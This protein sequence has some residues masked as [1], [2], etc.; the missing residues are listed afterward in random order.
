MRILI[1]FL[2]S[3]ILGF[4][5]KS[6]KEIARPQNLKTI[7]SSRTEKLLIKTRTLISRFPENKKER[8][9]DTAKWIPHKSSTDF[10]DINGNLIRTERYE[11]GGSITNYYTTSGYYNYQYN[12]KGKLEYMRTN[13]GDFRY[14]YNS[15]DSIEKIE[16]YDEGNLLEV[17]NYLYS[18]E[19]HIK[20]V[21]KKEDKMKEFIIKQLMNTIIWEI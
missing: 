8:E 3:L 12:V 19:N 1:I 18:Q 7:Q 13:Y 9:H 15:N 4:N 11:N 21:K 5:N 6:Q 14:Y 2:L 17:T 20:Q 16:L 10:Y